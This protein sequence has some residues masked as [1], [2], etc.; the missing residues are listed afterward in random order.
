MDELQAAIAR[1]CGCGGCR[2]VTFSPTF[3][4]GGMVVTVTESRPDGSK[5]SQSAPAVEPGGRP[6]RRGLTVAQ[7]VDDLGERLGQ[8]TCPCGKL[9]PGFARECWGCS[10]I[11]DDVPVEEAQRILADRYPR[12]ADV[13]AFYHEPERPLWRP[14]PEGPFRGGVR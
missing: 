13:P 8:W 14:A 12:P 7:L 5:Q 4:I 9:N 3:G 1:Q 6:T 10:R 2:T 11:R